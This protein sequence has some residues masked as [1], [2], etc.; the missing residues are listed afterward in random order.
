MCIKGKLDYVTKQC[1]DLEFLENKENKI[2][3]HVSCAV[4]YSKNNINRKSLI[5]KPKSTAPEI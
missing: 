2:I 1:G 4:T 5:T 3:W